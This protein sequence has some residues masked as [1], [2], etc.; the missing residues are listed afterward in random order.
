MAT[1]ATLRRGGASPYR[2]G[3]TSERRA[4]K[5]YEAV[6]WHV[7]RSPQSGSAVVLV[8]VASNAYPGFDFLSS[9]HWVQMKSSGYIRPAEKEAVLELARQHGGVP[10]LGWIVKNVLHRRDLRDGGMLED[11]PCAR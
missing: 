8:C 9:V 4:K 11:L 3:A 1:G 5:A 7:V 10:V 6:G 2:K